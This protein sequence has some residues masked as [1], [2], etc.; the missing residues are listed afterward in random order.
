MV[1]LAVMAAGLVP[2]LAFYQ[3]AV[4][5]SSHCIPRHIRHFLGSKFRQRFSVSGFLDTYLSADPLHS[6]HHQDL[7]VT[8]QAILTPQIP[9]GASICNCLHDNSGFPLIPCLWGHIIHIIS[10]HRF[11]SFFWTPP[12]F[13]FQF[14]LKRFFLSLFFLFACL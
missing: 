7:T 11:L 9:S 12:G 5:C 6:I 4:R 14:Y 2:P 3:S 13:V 8:F 10:L 1:N